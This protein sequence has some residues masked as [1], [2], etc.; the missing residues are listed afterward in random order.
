MADW[1]LT[2]LLSTWTKGGRLLIQGSRDEGSVKLQQVSGK[3][4]V[5]RSQSAQNQVEDKNDVTVN[6]LQCQCGFQTA[7][8]GIGLLKAEILAVRNGHTRV[9]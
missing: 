9:N 1:Q 7:R 8:H 2:D 4:V 5:I 3:T 6:I